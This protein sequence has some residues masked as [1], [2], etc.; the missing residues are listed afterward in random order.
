MKWVRERERETRCILYPVVLKHYQTGSYN[1]N[2]N[3]QTHRCHI[4]VDLKK[5]PVE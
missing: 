4:E 1:N 2:N 3:S 5:I